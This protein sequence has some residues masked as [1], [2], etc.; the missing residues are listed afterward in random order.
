MIIPSSSQLDIPDPQRYIGPANAVQV[1][2]VAD[3]IGSYPR[4]QNLEVEQRGQF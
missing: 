3:D 4:F 1:R 2:I